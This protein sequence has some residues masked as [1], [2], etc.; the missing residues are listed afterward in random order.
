M[1]LSF[2]QSCLHSSIYQTIDP[3][4]FVKVQI[5]LMDVYF[6]FYKVSQNLYNSLSNYVSR[7]VHD[8]FK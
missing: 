4:D 1:I 2:F 8:P 5:V 7:Y 3:M 6:H